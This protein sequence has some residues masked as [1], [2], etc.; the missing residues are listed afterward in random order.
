MWKIQISDCTEDAGFQA[1]NGMGLF[2]GGQFYA[3]YGAAT[4]VGATGAETSILAGSPSITNLNATQSFGPISTLPMPP[5]LVAN[6]NYGAWQ[7]GT[8]FRGDF[9]GTIRTNASTPTLRFRLGLVGGLTAATFNA[10]HDSAALTMASAAAAGSYFHYWFEFL[11]T[12]VASGANCTV[13]A[14]AGYETGSTAAAC[15]SNPVSTA[16]LTTASFDL[17]QA[18]NPYSWDIRVTWGTS[19]A[20][21]TLT[22]MYGRIGVVC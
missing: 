2:P 5:P 20:N 11:P 1:Q 9:W 13:I 3:Q 19:H 17:N 18:T 21:N 8:Q 22:V 12:V 7:L 14:T 4:A 6:S 10:F 15:A 16:P